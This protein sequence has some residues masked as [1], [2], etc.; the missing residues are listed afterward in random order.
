[1][2]SKKPMPVLRAPPP[3]PSS[4]SRNETSVSAVLRS[5]SAARL[6]VSIHCHRRVPPS[7]GRGTR[8]PRPGRSPLRARQSGRAVADPDLGEPPPEYRWRQTRL[9]AGRTVGR[10]H[11]VGAGDVVGEG[12]AARRADEYA[13]GM[14][15]VDGQRLGIGT[16]QLQVLRRERL[17]DRE[18]L[19]ASG[20]C[21]SRTIASPSGPPRAVGL[22]RV[23]QRARVR[24]RRPR[25]CPAHARPGPADRARPVRAGVRRWR[26]RSGQTDR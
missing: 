3:L 23:E 17:G 18:R 1:M 19:A 20:T 7:T 21:T 8:S 12:G 10:Q 14:A 4:A 15:N 11:V 13:A 16:D 25:S 9:E 5:I 2:W 26:S 22:E 6:M 24:D